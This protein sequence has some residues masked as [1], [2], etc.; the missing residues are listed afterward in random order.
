MNRLIPDPTDSTKWIIGSAA[1]AALGMQVGPSVLSNVHRAAACYG[2]ACVMHNPS[3]HHMR[4]WDLNWRDDRGLMER[5][6]PHDIGHPDPDDLAYR[7]S[8]GAPWW[9]DVHGCDG[10]CR[11]SDEAE[12][13]D[14]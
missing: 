2:R 5:I 1:D 13:Q 9:L 6:C 10:C 14:G 4:G 11:R 7:R 12:V 8:V 3:D